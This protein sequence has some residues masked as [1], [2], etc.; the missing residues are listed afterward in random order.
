MVDSTYHSGRLATRRLSLESAQ[1]RTF[2]RGQRSVNSKGRRFYAANKA[3]VV[4]EA[5]PVHAIFWPISNFCNDA[6]KAKAGSSCIV[7][8]TYYMATNVAK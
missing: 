6:W 7:A 2:S 8:F 1:V 5:D 4:I 3:I